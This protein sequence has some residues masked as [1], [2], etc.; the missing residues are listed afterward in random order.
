M[1]GSLA[2][3]FP[4]RKGVPRPLAISAAPM[5]GEFLVLGGNGDV[6]S[7]EEARS[8][9]EQAAWHFLEHKPLAGPASLVV[10]EVAA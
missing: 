8:W 5:A 7:V 3:W 2:Q 1:T 6:Y 4:L 9:F 10:A